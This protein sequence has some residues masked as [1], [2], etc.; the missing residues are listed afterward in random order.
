MSKIA[1]PILLLTLCACP[2][3]AHDGAGHGSIGWTFDV[4]ILGPIAASGICYAA[5]LARL[6]R[7][8]SIARVT[9]A[10]VAFFWCGWLGLV[11]ALVSPIHEFGEHLFTAHMV[12]HEILMAVSAPLLALSRPMGI[13]VWAMPRRV[14]HWLSRFLNLREARA[15]WDAMSRPSTATIL[16]AAAIWIW[17]H[18]AFFDATVSSVLLHRLQ[19]WSFFLSALVFWWAMIWR[20]DYGMAAF[21]LLLTMLH[22][23]ILGALI[24]LAPR[25]AYVHQTQDAV[26]W[27]LTPLEDQQLAG[28]VMW[29]PAGVV[30]AG[31]ALFL[32]ALWIKQSAHPVNETAAVMLLPPGEDVKL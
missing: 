18:P 3:L 30:Y 6:R 15:G 1:L 12:E 11:V 26:S 23:A 28:V 22:T 14:R 4:W 29:V 9:S 10:S 19:H 31:V 25:V 20:S 17:H 5:G 32:L 8:S 16:H 13:I 2:A 27:G 7:R 21:D 24:A